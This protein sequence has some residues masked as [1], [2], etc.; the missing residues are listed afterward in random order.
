SSAKVNVKITTTNTAGDFK[1]SGI[2]PVSNIQPSAL[3]QNHPKNTAKIDAMK[4]STKVVK[5]AV[6]DVKN[7]IIS[8]AKTANNTPSGSTI[9]ASH[10]KIFAGLGFNFDWRS[11]GK[12]T[13]GPVTINNP[14]I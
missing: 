10:F 1:Y 12:I 5:L 11:K 3:P 8:K 7:E 2:Y 4:N 6:S 14:P 9:I 13:V